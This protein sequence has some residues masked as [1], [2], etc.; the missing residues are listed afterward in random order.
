MQKTILLLACV[1]LVIPLESLLSQSSVQRKFKL[2]ELFELAET[3]NRSLKVTDYNE[4]ISAERLRE[5]QDKRLPSLD[6]SLSASY[7][8]DGW[9][10][11]RDFSNGMKAA[12]PDFGN[13]FALEATQVIFA[14]GAIRSTIK[15]AELDQLIARLDKEK[16]RQDIRFVIA[17][18]YFELLK[19]NNQQ[20]VLQNSI[21][22]TQKLLVQ[23]NAKC[24]QGASLRNNATR[25]ELQLQ[26]LELSLLKMENNRTIINNELVKSLQLPRGTR[27]EVDEVLITGDSSFLDAESWQNMAIQHS[28]LLKQTKAQEL[29]SALQETV[30][31]SAKLPKVIAFAGDKLDGP[32]TVEV[33]P[34]NKNLN[35]W[36][37]GVGVKLDLAAFYKNN[38]KQRM[39][40]LATSKTLVLSEQTMDQLATDIDAAYL[41]YQ[42]T[43]KVYQTELKGVELATENYTTTRN[44]YLNDLVLITEMLDADNEKVNA[45][46]NA[47]NAQINILYQYYQLKKITGT[48]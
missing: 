25:Y 31:K 26:A 17:G 21:Q 7:L 36:Y 29:Q 23:I 5:E 22:Q 45:E 11:N 28:P 38:T 18:F 30:A 35:Y 12:I 33:P 6:L 43:K 8:G 46:L 19:L 32:I 39:A 24:N 47:V 14:G 40:K 27:L 4:K 9:L 41:R 42:E 20:K 10:S 1:L 44:R 3:N 48:L 37:V 34:I 13:N 15:I 2:E 16:Y